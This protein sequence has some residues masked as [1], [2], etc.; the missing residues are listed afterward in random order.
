M[1]LR[2]TA[3]LRLG[4]G[5]LYHAGE[6]LTDIPKELAEEFAAGSRH[7]TEIV[8]PTITTTKQSIQKTVEPTAGSTKPTPPKAQPKTSGRKPSKPT[9]TVKSNRSKKR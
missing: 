8:I 4:S 9:P 1:K 6:Y 3:N 7:I 5:R 2:L